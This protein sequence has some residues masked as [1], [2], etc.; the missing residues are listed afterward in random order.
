MLFVKAALPAVLLSACAAEPRPTT[1]NG[2]NQQLSILVSSSPADGSTV[3]GAI[4]ELVLRFNPPA[5]LDEVTVA[6]PDG[7][8]PMMVHPAGE[9]ADYSLP[10]PELGPGRYTAKWRAST[11]GRQHLGSF[12]F[13]VK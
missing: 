8:M 6:G 13:T 5:R 10:L 1:S 11:Q 2:N 12:D 4:D 9:A 3:S 7:T